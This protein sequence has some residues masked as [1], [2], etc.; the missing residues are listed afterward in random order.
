MERV[1]AG[2]TRAPRI[3][4]ISPAMHPDRLHDL[5]ARLEGFAARRPGAY[6]LRVLLLGS[7]GYLYILAVLAALVVVDLLALALMTRGGLIVVKYLVLPLAAFSW[8]IVRALWVRIPPPEGRELH[9]AQAP[10]LFAMVDEVR[11]ALRAPRVHHVLLTDELNAS[12]VQVPRLGILGWQRNYLSLGL[13]LLHALPPEELRA[14]VAH[15]LAH[16]SGADG[17]GAAWVYRVH[18]T[19]HRL[20]DALA[21]ENHRGR[22]VF[23]RFFR[24][25]VP[26]FE[27]YSAV[28]SRSGELRAD[29]L[30]ASV[31]GA[32][33]A[34]STLLRVEVRGRFL[35]EVYWPEVMRAANREEEV[36]AAA[37]T[38]LAER[39]RGPVAPE[40][41]SAWAR[42]ACRAATHPGSS[43]PSLAD[44]LAALGFP[45]G[46]DG[47]HP[48]GAP[49]APLE[50]TAAEAFLPGLADVATDR[51]DRE[52]RERT[53]AWWRERVDQLRALRARKAALDAAAAGGSLDEPGAW[54]RARHAAQLALAA[55]EDA[56]GALGLLR[57]WLQAHPGHHEA[58][59][60]LG[61]I[62][63]ER[64]D[65]A[66]VE[67]L[68]GA[69]A[70]D[71]GFL[72]PACEALFEFHLARG[73]AEAAERVRE[74]A[75]ARQ[76]ALAG[77]QRERSTLHRDDV[78]LPHGAPAALLATLAGL[79]AG[80][81]RVKEAY[82]ARKQVAHFPEEPHY[83]LGVVLARESAWG[84]G[85]QRERAL[86][87]RLADGFDES[88]LVVV[89]NDAPARLRRRF[90]KLAGA[91]VHGRGAAATAPV[92]AHGA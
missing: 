24:W 20:M 25:Y 90:R 67:P 69:A 32:A 61:R 16:L 7:L 2:P 14:V 74:R 28:M 1:F 33:T 83:V 91:R 31:A 71:P 47:A 43:H 3:P 84:D 17:R 58:A 60:L 63:L 35:G 39:V 65:P 9:R 12:V 75:L 37:F 81:R 86:L 49:E 45:P 15:E 72:L 30:A 40:R 92:A 55:E 23:E 41:A 57:G 48:V 26:Y 36:P 79:L 29:R 46:E 5:T 66:G 87:Q 73:D 44:R 64:G 70:A 54:E 77:V 18:G 53:A 11:R 80:E 27:A 88:C 38:A 21:R 34:A 78:L 8:L 62:L 51:L 4:P 50:R 85:G 76:E 22:V 6:R 42:E 59:F 52:W 56:D 19:W 82:L 13:P 68:E 89:L 10:A